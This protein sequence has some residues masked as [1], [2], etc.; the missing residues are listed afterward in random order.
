MLRHVIQTGFVGRAVLAVFAVV[1]FALLGP[2]AAPP[3]APDSADATTLPSG[4]QESVVFSGLTNPMVVR[5]GAD[6]RIFVAEKS[7]VIKA[8]DSMSDTTPTTVADLNTNV[9]NFWDRGLLGMALDPNFPT[10]P[11]IYVLYTYDHEL[12]STASAPRWGTAGVYSDPCPS[13]PGPTTGGCVASGRL[14]RI[15]VSASST[16]V[17]PEQMLVEDWCQQFP[18][19]SIGTVEFGPDGALYASAGDGASFNFVDNGGAS[20]PC[21]DPA[22]EGGALRSQDIRSTGDPTGLDG[23]IIRVD[24]ATG[25]ALST[26]P[27]AGS[28]DPNARRI[29]AYGMRNPFR[30]T[31]RPETSEIWIG[32]VGWNDWEE[33]DR[34]L[35]P[36]DSAVENFGWPCYEGGSP[37]SG[38]DAANLPLCENLYST[39][40]AD[41]KPYFAYRHG[42]P[43]VSGDTCAT[44]NGSSVAGLSF[45]FAPT[46]STFP[47]EYQGALFF[48]DYSRNCIYVMQKNGNPIPSPGSIK[49]FATGAAGPVNLEFGPDRNL[50]YADFT[51]GTIRKI[52][53]TSPPS[54]CSNGQYQA[55]YFSNMT[56]SGSPA[57]SRCEPAPIDNTWGSGS[58][59][60]SL[61]ADGFSTRWTG[62]FDFAGGDTTFTATADDGIRVFVDGTLVIDGWAD[63]AP[64]TYTGT[65]TL[66]AG[67]HQVKV[68]YYENGGGAVAKV[69]WTGGTSS[70]PTVTST[71]PASGATGVAANV[72]P[73]ASF[74]EEMDPSTLTAT[75]F[76]LIRQGTSTA[77]SASVS[78]ANQVATLDPAASLDPGATYTATVKGGSSGARD[79]GGTPLASDVGWTFTTASATNTPP[80]PVIDTPSA[81]LTWKVGDAISFSGHATDS[82]QGSLAAS[83]L[84]WTLLIQ[85]CPSGG[86]HTHTAQSW[87]GVASG[88]F[89]A[90]DHDYPSYLTLQLTATDAA[91]A[92]ATT[93]VDLQPQTTVL[94]FASAPSGLQIAVNSSSAATP[95]SRT[96]IVGS[97]NSISAITPQSLSGTTYD[98][99]AWSDAGAQTHTVIAPAAAT[100]HVATYVIAPPRNSVIPT[101]SGQA[102][103]GRTV[104]VSNGTWTGSQPMTF[105]YQWLR[106]SGTTMGS[107]SVIVGA[108]ANSYVV[109]SANLGF[110]L[111]ASVTATNPGGSGTA[112]STATGK[113]NR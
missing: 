28:S 70:T 31:F 85:H 3:P 26:N 101:I 112:T 73:T 43:V 49:P 103:V 51:G 34:I 108:T 37:Q 69:S 24:P 81:I 57:L 54:S 11:Y 95:F 62:S 86:C 47:A 76:T 109:S 82:E 72:S 27:N 60:P 6:G 32:D 59:D 44:Q 50:Y 19:H 23:S 7:G 79:T 22:N 2:T 17:G 110:R 96:V 107:C 67:P 8:F 45:E 15:Q 12:G 33:I 89:S 25:D 21:G 111:R 20:G 29:I 10:N 65:R 40:N 35:S 5:F 9:Y 48:A 94:G 104:T 64:T 68:E 97:S 74:S 106:C 55:D 84:S 113:I 53:P 105:T 75:S 80:T 98:F 56:L 92:G 46:G 87:T 4:F 63:Q 42:S 18:S 88:S 38:Y 16:Q 14:S 93:S 30:F 77:V 39:P 71:T 90:P 13:P 61:P 58:P 91:G 52:A 66:T 78:Y 36:T 41:T 99:S 83:A 1:A 102:R 100:T